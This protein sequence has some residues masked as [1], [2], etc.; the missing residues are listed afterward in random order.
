METDNNNDRKYLERVK[1]MYQGLIVSQTGLF[2][3]GIIL[4]YIL[5]D[6]IPVKHLIIWFACLMITIFYR[7]II[8]VLFNQSLNKSSI[9][10]KSM[11]NRFVFGVLIASLVL[12]A[13]GVFLYPEDSL[14]HQTILQL[15]LLGL[16]AASIGTLTPSYKSVVIFMTLSVLPITIHII[17]NNQENSL[18]LALFFLLFLIAGLS[19]SKRFNSSIKE[20]LLLRDDIEKNQQKM[21]KNDDKYRALYENSE[22]AMMLISGSHFFKAN[23]AAVKLLGYDSTEHLL[24]TPPFDLCPE[25]QLNGKTSKQQAREMIAEVYETGFYRSEWLFKKVNNEVC[26]AD[27][28]LTSIEFD[29]KQAVLCVGRDISKSKNLEQELIDANKAKS[30]F[31]ANMSHEIRTPMNGVIGL[32]DLM[33]NNP[34]DEDQIKRAKTIRNSANSMLNIINDILDFSKIEAG[35]LEIELHDFNFKDFMEDFLSSIVN[36]IEEK[37]LKLNYQPDPELDGWFKGDSGR[38]RQI[39]TNLIGNA[40]KFTS[41]GEIT[42]GFEIQEQNDDDFL[43]RFFV[44]DTGIGIDEAQQKSIFQRFTQ[45]DNS[46][47]R[48][49]GGTGLGLS[50]C[51]QLSLLMNG[52]I[53]FS[54][55]LNKGTKFWFTVRLTKVANPD[56]GSQVMNKQETFIPVEGRVLVVDDNQTNLF[57]AKQMLEYLGV[58]TDITNNGQEAI[59]CLSEQH[60]DLIF[61]DCHMPVL[62]GYQATKKIREMKFANNSSKIPIIAITAGA[63]KGDRERCLA[64]GMDDYIAKP[65][66]V[67]SIQQ[68]LITWLPIESSINSQNEAE[69]NDENNLENEQELI[70]DYDDLMDRLMANKPLINE[71]I[72]GFFSDIETK[73]ESLQTAIS[74]SQYKEIVNMTHDLKGASANLSLN[75]FS[76]LMKDIEMAARNKNRDELELKSSQIKPLL[77]TT[78]TQ[79][80]QQTS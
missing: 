49:Y 11:E 14:L 57:V 46:T 16:V 70:F 39:L 68:K 69:L 66:H 3:S 8:L 9:T 26:P 13:S 40:I 6:V 22:E 12:G 37:K 18:I 67:E 34:L 54:S 53:G 78:K 80:L 19:N 17:I 1:L 25:H 10:P 42:L 24:N 47:T 50:I 74:E 43:I 58:Q 79:V 73:L 41:K 20:T 5:K 2:I 63:M 64:A 71:I 61:M 75:R 52:D 31:L 55:T 77:T 4:C 7:L 32:N 59:N 51:R 48:V 23:D 28:T 38:I 76:A 29:G 65:I 56:K 45:A 35:K 33:L 27:V 30:E 72:S 36:S 21:A 60:Y 44:S 62:D 15:F